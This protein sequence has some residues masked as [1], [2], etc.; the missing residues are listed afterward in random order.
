MRRSA[1]IFWQVFLTTLATVLAVVVMVGL[2]A[3][4]ALSRAFD[5]YLLEMAARQASHN[6][7]GMMGR[8][9]GRIMLGQAEQT[10]IKSVDGAVLLAG[11][12][13]VLLAIVIAYFLARRLSD[14][15]RQ[16]EVAALALA[17]G[18]LSSRTEPSGPHEIAM[19]GEAFN[20]MAQRLEDSEEL[21][22][23][24]VAD[25][26]HELR[27]PIAAAR[28]QAEGMAEGVLPVNEQR[29]GSLVEDMGHLTRL[30]DD[31]Q[32]LALA[33][34][35]R[36]SYERSGVDMAALACRAVE[37][38]AVTATPGVAVTCE[39]PNAVRVFGDEGR[40]SQVV[41]NLLSNA[42]RHTAEGSVTV[43]VTVEDDEAVVR[44]VD[45]GEG[46]PAEDL[47]R[48]FQRFYRADSARAS[49]TGGAGLG[50]AI[51]ARIVHDH[52][53]DVFAEST[54]GGGATVGFRLPLSR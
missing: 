48:V 45:T 19:L 43:R 13:A 35:G 8:G 41:R 30:V 46:I 5:T 2:V 25:V 37:A 14:P 17:D 10:F 22:R 7:Q 28:A 21:R 49:D 40:L 50:L 47:P 51:T 15:I 27:N 26:A 1:T 42:I 29:L 23:R 4:T 38:V 3:R 18:D 44:V 16:L 36:L 11:L 54:P 20:H 9:M 32:E 31:L 24:M 33:E 34:A 39:A 52:D 12:A 6:G 53:G